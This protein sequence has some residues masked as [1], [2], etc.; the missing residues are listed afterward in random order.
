MKIVILTIVNKEAGSTL[1]RI[2]QY[3]QLLEENGAS[4]IFVERKNITKRI[5]NTIKEADLVINQKCLFQC[6]LAKK[7]IKNSKRIIF[8]FDDANIY[9]SWKTISFVG[10]NTN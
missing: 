6:C 2:M 3:K 4:I 10:T 9:T 8:D 5:L 1:Y 7:I